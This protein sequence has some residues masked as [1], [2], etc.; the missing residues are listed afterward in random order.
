M[1]GQRVGLSDKDILKINAMYSNKCNN[2]TI[3]VVDE[4]VQMQQ[5]QQQ[6]EVSSKPFPENYVDSLIHWFE[7]LVSLD[8]IYSAFESKT[9]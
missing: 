8:F 7:S 1:L 6:Q 5:Q 9:H 3:N 4:Y 2:H